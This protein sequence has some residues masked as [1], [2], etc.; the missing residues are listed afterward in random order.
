M[1]DT[2]R[3]MYALTFDNALALSDAELAAVVD[4]WA[5]GSGVEPALLESTYTLCMPEILQFLKEYTPDDIYVNTGFDDNTI[6]IAL[7]RSPWWP[8]ILDEFSDGRAIFKPQFKK[9]LREYST[10]IIAYL[11]TVNVEDCRDEF[12]IVKEKF[13]EKTTVNFTATWDTLFGL[14]HYHYEGRNWYGTNVVMAEELALCALVLDRQKYLEQT[15]KAIGDERYKQVRTTRLDTS[16]SEIYANTAGRSW[17]EAVE[18]Y[19]A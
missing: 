12:A 16:L 19:F 11:N 1:L 3:R 10:E 4:A 6:L 9:W 8:T 15:L 18:W 13:A 5:R 2:I 7:Y 17:K 14:F